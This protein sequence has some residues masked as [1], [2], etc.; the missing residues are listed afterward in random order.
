MDISGVN[1]RDLGEAKKNIAMMTNYIPIDYHDSKD[2]KFIF[3]MQFNRS[4][5]GWER[6]KDGKLK[7][8][9]PMVKPGDPKNP[10]QYNSANTNY[11][12]AHEGGHVISSTIVQLLNGL[13]EPEDRTREETDFYF[14][15]TADELIYDAAISAM[16]QDEHFANA[17]NE[18]AGV[19]DTMSDDEKREAISHAITPKNLF[20]MGYSSKYTANA[21]NPNDLF[22]EAIAD[23]RLRMDKYAEG[24]EVEFNPFSQ[25]LY[26]MSQKLMENPAEQREFLDRHRKDRTMRNKRL[27][28]YSPSNVKEGD[29]PFS[30]GMLYEDPKLFRITKTNSVDNCMLS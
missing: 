24:K 4:A 19:T 21:N 18:M 16:E 5:N 10:Y 11:A 20:Q 26:T 27:Q 2:D 6:D 30:R 8:K 15:I 22:A 29:S 14:G 7:L 13:E 25:S 9:F 12:A 3:S 28:K 23:H 17:V 1:I